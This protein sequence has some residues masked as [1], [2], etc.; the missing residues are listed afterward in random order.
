[1]GRE[2][3]VVTT[4]EGNDYEMSKEGFRPGGT[5]VR[6]V[7]AHVMRLSCVIQNGPKNIVDVEK[8]LLAGYSKF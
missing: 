8:P 4:S 5:F 6:A 2:V 7:L 1:M 3:A